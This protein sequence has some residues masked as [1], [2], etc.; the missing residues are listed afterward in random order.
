MS[1]EAEMSATTSGDIKSAEAGLGSRDLGMF[2]VLMKRRAIEKLDR[3]R[4]KK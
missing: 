2:S 3:R 4:I 1:T